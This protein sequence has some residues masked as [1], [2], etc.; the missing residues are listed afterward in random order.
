MGNQRGWPVACAVCL[1]LAVA[2]Y[3]NHF[4]NAFHFDDFHTVVQNPHVR[5]IGNPLRFFLD[6]STYSALPI[7]QQYR[8]LVTASLAFDYWLGDGLDSTLWFHLTTFGWFLVQAVLMLALYRAILNKAGFEREDARW[9]ALA[10]TTLY[11][12]HPVSAET[13]NYITQRADL[14]STIGV[15]AATMLYIAKPGRRGTGLY[16]VPMIVG[17]LA[18]PSALMLPAI[19]AVYAYLFERD[20]ID[21]TLSKAMTSLRAALPALAVAALMGGLLRWMTPAAY[22]LGDVDAMRY[23][24]TQPLVAVRYIRAF[25]YPLTL[26]AD[27]DLKMLTSFWSWPA[28]LGILLLMGLLLTIWAMSQDRDTRPI[29]F[30]LLWFLLAL[31]PTSVPPLAEPENDHRMFFPFVGLTLSVT[32]AAAL[33]VRRFRGASAFAPWR[34]AALAGAAAIV[35]LPCAYGTHLRNQ[36]WSSEE[37]LWLDVTLKS[38]RNG[39]GLMN[40]GVARMLHGDAATALEYFRRA[41]IQAPAYPLVYVNLGVAYA[42]LNDH[43]RAEAAFREAERID[44]SDPAT[45]SFYAQWLYSRQRLPESQSQAK[46][47]I[48]LAPA[49]VGPRQLLIRT[50]LDEADWKRGRALVQET[51]RLFP[52]DVTTMELAERLPPG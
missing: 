31:M 49:L 5:E 18:K 2:A 35:L 8:P 16:L 50:Y 43:T 27:T 13:V 42:S 10:A 6:G 4:L 51:L 20:D 52:D 11:V 7:Q 41:Q 22:R 9:W 17:A 47:T 30:G 15:V 34:K 21:T 25:F 3:A 46:R 14:Y 28:L 33:A 36:V 37:S 26:S 44:P 39:R 45:H 12:V 40:Y 1:A 24:I 29:A 23:W 19:I 38:P 48:E 32:A